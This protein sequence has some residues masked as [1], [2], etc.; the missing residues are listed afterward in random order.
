[1]NF[2]IYRKLIK[3]SWWREEDIG[4]GNLEQLSWMF[5]FAFVFHGSPV[6]A[7][8]RAELTNSGSLCLTVRAQASER[9]RLHAKWS[10]R[11]HRNNVCEFE[12][13]NAILWLRLLLVQISWSDLYYDESPQPPTAAHWSNLFLFGRP[14]FLIII[15]CFSR[16]YF[17]CFAC[18]V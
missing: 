9:L 17:C 4:I 16:A 12:H 13:P 6:Q 8:D 7:N 3:F 11:N 1:M 14:R 5:C 10:F 15:Y 18:F 2:V